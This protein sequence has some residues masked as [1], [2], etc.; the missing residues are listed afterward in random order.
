MGPANANR[1]KPDGTAV[2]AAIQDPFV[3]KTIQNRRDGGVGMRGKR[4]SHFAS[5]RLGIGQVPHDVQ[6]PALQ[7]AERDHAAGAFGTCA[8][9]T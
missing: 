3:D 8:W 2:P 4:I 6:H 7:I 9:I 5:G 1:S